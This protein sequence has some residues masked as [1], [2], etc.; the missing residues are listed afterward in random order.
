MSLSAWASTASIT[1]KESLIAFAP[2]TDFL[3]KN[4]SY[5]N[6][7][8]FVQIGVPSRSHIPQYKQLDDELDTLVE[9]INWKWGEGSWQPIVFL[10]AHHGQPELMA[11][12]RLGHFCI[13]S[14][15][16]DGLNLVAKEYVSS[17]FDDD[18]VLILSQFTGAA[19]ELTDALLVNPFS[20]DE[21]AQAI[22][23][24]LDMPAAER[25]RRMKRMREAVA[26]NNIY[27]WA[28]KLLS[29]LL[30]LDSTELLNGAGRK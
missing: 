27:R 11:L 12:H 1:P 3:E 14:S 24:A 23:V 28:G 4:P 26:K 22:K 2:S 5:R 7:F 16:H 30:Q 6:R 8:K 9:Q 10:K 19:R 17:R 18:G 15:L 13:V 25:Q 29:G 21:I 20:I